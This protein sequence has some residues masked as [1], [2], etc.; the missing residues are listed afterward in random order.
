MLK[1]LSREETCMQTSAYFGSTALIQFWL[2]LSVPLTGFNP[3]TCLTNKLDT[4]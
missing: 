3:N 2:L 1:P 4:H